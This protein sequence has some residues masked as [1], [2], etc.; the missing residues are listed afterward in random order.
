MKH[1]ASALSSHLFSPFVSG[2]AGQSFSPT[3]AECRM[4]KGVRSTRQP[5]IIYRP[6]VSFDARVWEPKQARTGNSP[7]T[8]APPEGRREISSH[9]EAIAHRPA[10]RPSVRE[11]HEV[12][13]APA[14]R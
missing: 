14:G 5:D 10:K 3:E 7:R 11:A 2:V 13:R 1:R 4:R 8:P 6:Q 9:P 12:A